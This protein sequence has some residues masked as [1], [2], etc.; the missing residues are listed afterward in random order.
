[1]AFISRVI[2]NPVLFPENDA[3]KKY[4][5]QGGCEDPRIVED[6]KGTY[7]MTYTAF[8][9]KI[10]RLMVATSN[11]F[12]KM[13]KVRTCFCES[14]RMENIS[15]NGQN[16]DRLFPLM[17]HI[18]KITATKINGKYWMYWGD[19]FIWIAT[20]DDLINWTPVEMD[21]GRKIAG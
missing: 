4:E 18:G 17:M 14:L 21:S 19:Q 12:K 3:Q 1:M 6:E 10:A 13:D 16:Q 2:A 15:T 9:G 7:Y 8:E 11:R 5:W 20:S